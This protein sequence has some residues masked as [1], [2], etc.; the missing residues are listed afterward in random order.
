MVLQS[1]TFLDQ[2][3]NETVASTATTT[4]SSWAPLRSMAKSE[5]VGVVQTRMCE[6]RKKEIVRECVCEKERERMVLSTQRKCVLAG[7]CVINEENVRTSERKRVRSC[8]CE[9]ECE[10]A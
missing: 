1:S 5:R 9:R 7:V 6:S 8:V 2:F 10:G 4:F 3:S